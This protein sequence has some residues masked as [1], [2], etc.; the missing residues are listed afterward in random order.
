MITA[1]IQQ[2]VAAELPSWASMVPVRLLDRKVGAV[3]T[4]VAD[5]RQR[6]AF[7][8]WTGQQ[9]TVSCL[10]IVFRVPD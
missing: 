5:E 8:A 1:G 2:L 6:R 7:A 9:P 10:G 4:S 3:V